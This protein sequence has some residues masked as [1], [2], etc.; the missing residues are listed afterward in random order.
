[1]TPPATLAQIL[2]ETGPMLLDFDGPICA[3]FADVSSAT[4]AD[5]LRQVL[6]DHG[7]VFPQHIAEEADPLEVLRYAATLGNQKLTTRVDD[8]LRRAE[9]HAIDHANATRYAREVIVAAHN[10]GRPLA[11]VSNNAEPAIRVYLT[12]HR[13]T[14]YIDHIVGRAHG[15]PGAMKPNPEPVRAA[16]AALGVKPTAC[17]L[18]GDSPSDISAGQAAG[19]RTIG[20]AN[21]AG[22][23]ERL[24]AAGADA[25][26]DGANDLAHLA[27]LLHDE[28]DLT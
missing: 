11:I 13:L 6:T 26:A 28:A 12:Q 5:Q 10:A 7:A 19:V 2:A 20:Y 4:V 8:Q 14:G 16:V 18:V 1:M 25:V 3:V 9:R 17:V 24:T 23:Y 22:K 21:K 15:D 27:R